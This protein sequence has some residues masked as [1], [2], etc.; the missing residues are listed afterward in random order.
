M[1]VPGY[2]FKRIDSDTIR[3]LGNISL[4]ITIGGVILIG[5]AQIK[6]TILKSK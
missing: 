5:L 1:S 6:A 2:F 3:L 4:P